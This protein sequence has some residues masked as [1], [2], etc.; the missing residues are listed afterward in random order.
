MSTL[1]PETAEDEIPETARCVDC[2]HVRSK[3]GLSGCRGGPNCKCEGFRLKPEFSHH[4]E[5]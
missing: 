4:D 1:E 3:H 2:D 5:V